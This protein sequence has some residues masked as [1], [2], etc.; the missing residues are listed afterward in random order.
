MG[1]GRTYYDF[2]G[3]SPTATPQQIRRA[4][5]ALMKRCHPDHSAHIDKKRASDFAAFVNRSYAVLKDP[6]KRARYDAYLVRRSRGH[7]APPLPRRPLLVGETSRRSRGFDAASAGVVVLAVAASLVAIAAVSLP[8]QSVQ[9]LIGGVQ[10]VDAAARPTSEALSAADIRRQVRL[11]MTAMPDQ[12]LLASKD[13]FRSAGDQ[14]SL[15]ET[16]LCVLFDDAYL[17]WSQISDA[18]PS[19]SL[20]FNDALVRVRQRDAM[21]AVG[22]FQESRLDQL[23]QLALTA[24]LAEIRAKVDVEEKQDPFAP[25]AADAAPVRELSR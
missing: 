13:C 10:L 7:Q 23:R 19:Q 24:L 21:A 14:S 8:S 4:Y 6:R 18:S 25:V 2:L 9:G 15:Y 5:V 1:S 20:Y 22:S 3:V 17:D 11:A 16:Q 12:A